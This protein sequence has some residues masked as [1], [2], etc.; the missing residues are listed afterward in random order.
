MTMYNKI[1]IIILFLFAGLFTACEEVI[2]V[3]L[4]EANPVLVIEANLNVRTQEAE[5]KLT[6]TRSY[7]A[8]EEAQP[9]NDAVV[10][11]DIDGTTT[12]V[13]LQANGIYTAQIPATAGQI[14]TLEVND[15]GT[16][17]SAVSEVPVFVPLDSL[18]DEFVEPNSLFDGGYFVTLHLLDPAGQPNWYRVKV[19]ENDSLYDDGA[20]L[21]ITD[22]EF[23]DGLE[24]EGSL[25][26]FF[27]GE[28]TVANTPADVVRMELINT[29]EA[30]YEYY[31]SLFD[32]IVNQ[33]GGSTAAPANP[34][35][36]LTGGALGLFNV[37]QSD[38]LEI[39]IG[40]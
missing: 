10:T 32:I 22:D 4:N 20:D 18:T 13:E 21:Q 28:D 16:V 37:F 14:A 35:T 5:V 31:N 17:H 40:E 30:T 2:D 33:G 39:V 6:R 11:I 26:Y 8:A 36:N 15:G 7:F 34:N 23:F 38:T 1:L 12:N 3:E 25:F 19:W 9:V 29:S 24:F 27:D